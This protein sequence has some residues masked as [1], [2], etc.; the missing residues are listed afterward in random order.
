MEQ[1]TFFSYLRSLLHIKKISFGTFFLVLSFLADI[2]QVANLLPS[3]I[4]NHTGILSMIFLLLGLSLLIFG[5]FQYA[6]ILHH[7]YIRL[8]NE[9]PQ[10]LAFAEQAE[11]L[12]RDFRGILVKGIA[13]SSLIGKLPK[14]KFV[15]FTRGEN[16]AAIMVLQIPFIADEHMNAQIRCSIENKVKVDGKLVNVTSYF[17]LVEVIRIEKTS[18]VAYCAMLENTDTQWM[19]IIE[20]VKKGMDRSLPT[21]ISFTPDVVDSLKQFQLVEMKQLHKLLNKFSRF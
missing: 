20:G 15:K 10:R 2:Q 7:E 19:D 11:S 21:S 18:S 6:M 4:K 1:F 16:N 17:G 9:L 5:V 3:D 12:I 8:K 14:I 13:T